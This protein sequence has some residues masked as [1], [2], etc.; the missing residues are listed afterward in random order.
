MIR[1]EFESCQNISECTAHNTDQIHLRLKANIN[2]LCSL[3]FCL[4]GTNNY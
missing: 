2:C 1:Y 4:R 3:R